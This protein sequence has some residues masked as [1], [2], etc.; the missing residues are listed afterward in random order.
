MPPVG[1]AL[2]AGGLSTVNPCGFALMPAFLSLYVGAEERSLP[3]A[4]TRM[5]QGLLVGAVVSAGLLTVFSVVGIPIIYGATRVT[6]AIPWGGLVIGVALSVLGVALVAGKH[7]SFAIRN[8]IRVQRDRRV[9]SMYLFGAGYGIASLGCTLPVFLAIVGASLASRGAGDALAVFGAYG[10]G[11]SI[12]VMAL[13]VTAAFVRTGLQRS[14]KRLLP[15]M[16]RITGALLLVTGGY[17]TYYW[18]R[19]L[20]GSAATLS[21]DPL[22]GPVERFIAS[23][24]RTASSGGGRTFLIVAFALVAA[25]AL[26]SLWQW[27]GRLPASDEEDGDLDDEPSERP[28]RRAG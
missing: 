24:Q 18:A 6:R 20:F 4:P 12:V 21:R 15:H 1:I 3:R 11:M 26:V 14:L 28:L 19:V 2:I 27:A 8:P 13:A 5:M 9:R 10:I 22:V 17:L 16:N 25:A 7:L 23:I